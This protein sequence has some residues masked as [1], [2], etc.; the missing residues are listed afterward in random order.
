MSRHFG[1]H[2]AFGT[3]LML[4]LGIGVASVAKGL[5]EETLGSKAVVKTP[6]GDVIDNQLLKIMESEQRMLDCLDREGPKL[7]QMLKAL[8]KKLNSG[9]DTGIVPDPPYDFIEIAKRL[10]LG[11]EQTATQAYCEGDFQTLD[12][13]YNRA[14]DEMMYQTKVVKISQAAA[15]EKLTGNVWKK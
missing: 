15:Y 8:D 14:L 9:K 12:Q 1:M 2:P 3:L 4:S 13:A 5:R 7:E 10:M 6:M 11:F